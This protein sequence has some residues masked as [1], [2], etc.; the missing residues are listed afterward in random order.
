MRNIRLREAEEFPQDTQTKR[1]ELG[2]E[3]CSVW[4]QSFAFGDWGHPAYK[5]PKSYTVR[6][7]RRRAT[8]V[9]GGFVETAGFQ[10]SRIHL[11]TQAWKGC[12]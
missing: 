8:V 9:R 10:L 5:Y 2:F 1:E 12:S 4:L 3:S 6:L 11:G 7:L